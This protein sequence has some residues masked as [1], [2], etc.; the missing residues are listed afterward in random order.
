MP[1]PT[2]TPTATPSGMEIAVLGPTVTSQPPLPSSS[3]TTTTP[4][5]TFTGLMTLHLGLLPLWAWLTIYLSLLLIGTLEYARSEAS[6]IW[7]H[8]V[9]T[10]SC[11]ETGLH[12]PPADYDKYYGKEYRMRRRNTLVSV[13]LRS[14]LFVHFWWLISLYRILFLHRA[15]EVFQANAEAE[16]AETPAI[17]SPAPALSDPPPAYEA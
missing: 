15:H 2:P 11:A 8:V 5:T 9:G 3:T 17:P 16:A 13:F 1:T 12:A 6:R 7:L 14:I 10:K 4:L